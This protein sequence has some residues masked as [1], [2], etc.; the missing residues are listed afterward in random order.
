MTP[1]TA[2]TALQIVARHIHTPPPS[3]SAI[4]PVPI[5]A[6]L[7]EVVIAC[8]AK[9]PSDRPTTARELCDRLGQ[10]GVEPWSREDARVW[11]ETRLEPEAAVSLVD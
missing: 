1:S 2:D 10:C 9:K 4:S 8:L 11:W 7:E 5:P 6:E 3:P